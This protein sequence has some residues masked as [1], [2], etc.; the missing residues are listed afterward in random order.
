MRSAATL[1]LRF[2]DR[3]D[4]ETET[5][6]ALL[7]ALFCAAL[8][9]LALTSEPGFAQ[10]FGTPVRKMPFGIGGAEGAASPPGNA[11]VAWLIAQQSAFYQAINAAVRHAKA[12]GSAVFG[13]IGLSFL[14]GIFHAAGPGHG[15]AVIA[16]Y[17]VANERALKR[18]TLIAFLAAALQG[19]VAIAIIGIIA[20]ALRGT[21]QQMTAAGGVI[22]MMSYAAIALFGL[23]LALRKGRALLLALRPRPASLSAAGVGT[24]E[25]G[26]VHDASC[27]H[28]HMPDA[29]ALA[30][31][32]SAR[33]IAA[34]VFAAGLR[35]C[36]GAILV[37]IYALS[38]GIFYAGIGA[39][40]AMSLG[41]AM[42]TSGLA[43]LAVFA[44]MLALRLASGGSRLGET[45]IRGLELAAALLVMLLGTGLLLGFIASQGGA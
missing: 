19:L 17:M 7:L 15:K 5:R 13:L 35:P 29:A 33:D 1:R 43:A 28:L 4:P 38:Q 8:A 42:T 25:A 36:T 34:T 27:G 37:L 2:A 10:G 6:L 40:A 24:I 23:M 20:I 39:V 12:D 16:S 41:T 3:F 21:A 22:E 32:V 30:G 31:R 45:L 9:L 26:H 14:Y 44:K 11:I 18:G